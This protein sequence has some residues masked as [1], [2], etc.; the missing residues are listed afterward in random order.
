[1]DI[2]PVIDIRKGSAVRAIAGRR[3]DYLR[4][5]SP[6]ARTSAPID[7]AEGLMSLY[8]FQA[9]YI[10]DLDAIEGRGDNCGSI[11]EIGERFP[12]LSLWVDAGFRRPGAA[13]GWLELENVTAVFGSETLGSTAALETLAGD[14]R[15]ILSLD[16][17]GDVLLGPD[18]LLSAP[19][20]WPRRVIVMTLDRVGAGRGPDLER[21]RAI[22]RIA[23]GRAV[24]AAGGVRGP[25]DLVALAAA[26]ADGALVASAL[27]DGK[28]T[29]AD[30]MLASAPR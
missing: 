21:L 16:F 14:A 2:V 13:R 5:V 10:A 15:A 19:A 27:H 6:L 25:D 12:H 3:D 26:G 1:M 4:L 17:R 22:G 24:I 23:A 9:L 8:A 29:A 11:R 18:G 28:L 30:L 20:L 7:V